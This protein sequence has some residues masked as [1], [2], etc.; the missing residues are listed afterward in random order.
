MKEKVIEGKG[1]VKING[2]VLIEDF[3]FYLSFSHS[4]CLLGKSGSG[5]TKLLKNLLNLDKIKNSHYLVLAY[6]LEKESKIESV[7]D[8]SC[9]SQSEK[10]FVKKIGEDKSKKEYVGG[11]FK[12]ICQRPDF[13]FLDDIS[14]IFTLEERQKIFEII[15][16]HK[17]AVFYVTHDVEDVLFFPYTIILHKRNFARRKINEIDGLFVTFLCKLIYSVKIIWCY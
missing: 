1:K 4:I 13:L 14:K 12:V 16:A 10:L 15:R 7:L 3:F 11:L 6:F 8:S 5:K 9:L 2:T 17:I